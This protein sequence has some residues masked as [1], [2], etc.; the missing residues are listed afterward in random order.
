[1]R[2]LVWIL[3][4]ATAWMFGCSKD[5]LVSDFEMPLTNG[6]YLIQTAP[7]LTEVYQQ[8]IGS[9]VGIPAKVVEIA[10]NE[11]LIL[12]KRQVLTNRGKFP[13]DTVTIPAPGQFDWWVVN[14]SEKQRYGPMGEAD[15]LTKIR[16][17]PRGGLKLQKISELKISKPSGRDGH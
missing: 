2:R 7:D 10:W 8:E 1:M 16:S 13:G 17:L 6:Y 14:M 9:R 15:F 11:E 12:A 3:C 4:C 5:P